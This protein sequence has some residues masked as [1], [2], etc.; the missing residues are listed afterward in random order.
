MAKERGRVVKGSRVRGKQMKTEV[1]IRQNSEVRMQ[2]YKARYQ[3][4]QRQ[5]AEVPLRG[6]YEL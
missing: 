5:K 1:E 6:N 4:E 2:K 3:I